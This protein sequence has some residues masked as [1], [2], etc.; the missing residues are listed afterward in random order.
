M[1]LGRHELAGRHNHVFALLGGEVTVDVSG[2]FEQVSRVSL[3][4]LHVLQRSLK[5]LGLPDHLER[6]Q[7]RPG[8]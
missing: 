5:L 3:Q 4:E 8:Q 7:I 1:H 6:R 2:V